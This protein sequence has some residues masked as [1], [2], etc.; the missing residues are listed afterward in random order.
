MASTAVA[1]AALAAAAGAFAPGPRLQPLLRARSQVDGF[2]P[3]PDDAAWIAPGKVVAAADEHGQYYDATVLELRT[4]ADGGIGAAFVQFIGWEDW[5]SEWV[6]RESLAY[7]PPRGAPPVDDA[8]LSP[9][10]L[11][12][13]RRVNRRSQDCWQFDQF[14]KA[15]AG[16]WRGAGE[17]Y[18]AAGRALT[19]AA[20]FDGSL[21]LERRDDATVAS[22]HDAWALAVSEQRT[23]FVVLDS[24]GDGAAEPAREAAAP[25]LGA[26][27]LKP[28]T[29]RA[30]ARDDGELG[31]TAANGEAFSTARVDGDALVVDVWARAADDALSLR[32]AYEKTTGGA[33]AF[34]CCD[35]ARWCP[36][37]GA[38]AP[39]G[40]ALGT[41]LYD[42]HRRVEINHWPHQ[43]SNL[44]SSVTSTSIRLIFGRIDGSPRVL[45]A[46]PKLS[47]RNG[48]IRSH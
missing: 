18:V 14:T 31:G 27:T 10:A 19:V 21:D 42:A 43:T 13:R 32:V 29:F 40:D 12:E 46:R 45:E 34:A 26:V 24:L 44:S 39:A 30:E 17:R 2:V 16:S 28:A 25:P 6:A 9:E 33:W 3:P 20:T 15:F 48:R 8:A 47:R 4:R 38:A 23:N 5:P 37:G 35:L 1:V 41:G 7:L 11:A 22:A 36:A